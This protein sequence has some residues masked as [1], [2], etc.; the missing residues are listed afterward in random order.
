[1]APD[2]IV[3]YDGDCGICQAS[4]SW[5]QKHVVTVD[6]ISHHDYGV[7]ELGS[8]WLIGTKENFEGADAVA[9]I[10]MMSDSPWLRRCGAVM[11]WPVVRHL[12]TVVYRIIARYRRHLSR[13][14]GMNACAVR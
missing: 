13:L 12:A 2:G 6:V 8:V 1:M 9:Q 10:L 14:L 5:I 3:V 4:A 7:A 11:R